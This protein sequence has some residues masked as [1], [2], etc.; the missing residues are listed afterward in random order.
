MHP[1]ETGDHH[2]QAAVNPK[3]PSQVAAL[4]L[5]ERERFA[6]QPLG[7]GLI[8]RTWLVV[9][10]EGPR[11]VLQELNTRVFPDPERI[12]RNLRVLQSHFRSR[13]AASGIWPELLISRYGEPCVR[14]A[15]GGVWRALSF[16]PGTTLGGIETIAQAEEIGCA[17][18][19]FHACFRDLDPAL[20]E[21]PLP[22][23]HVAP[24]YLAR[25]DA[26]RTR[27]RLEDDE[28]VREALEFV[29]ARRSFV[30]VL[31]DAKA[32]GILVCR[33]IHGDPKLDNVR[34]DAEGRKA[35]CLLD[36]DTVQA[37]LWHYDLGDCLR[38]C[39][40]RASESPADPCIVKFDLALCEA[41]LRGY[42][43]R[44]RVDFPAP[45][46]AFLFAAIRLLPLE[47][48]LRFLTDHLAG[49]V[50]FKTTR[51]GQNLER[52]VT[53]FRLVESI[54]H[55]EAEIREVIAAWDMA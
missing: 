38:S 6:L 21:N 51:R 10:E 39:C 23:F 22:D 5:P 35:L 40:N 44:V 34:F 14:D 53:Q 30:P 43:Q 46:R 13:G 55:H 26:L 18:G 54:E 8:H 15:A 48:G 47:L 49:D 50:Y 37:G 29:E 27:V 2:R 52:A 42:W 28:G 4:F 7:T 11:F 24:T 12:L 3:S 17:L 32:R 36:L 25:L 20:L 31:E 1:S 9:S 41:I 19:E 33:I 16:I 45:E